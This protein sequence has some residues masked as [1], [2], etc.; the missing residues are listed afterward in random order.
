M[1]I[2]KGSVLIIHF[3]YR[4]DTVRPLTSFDVKL[5]LYVIN[6]I[7]NSRTKQNKFLARRLPSLCH[8]LRLNSLKQNEG[9]GE[10][11]GEVVPLLN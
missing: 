10:G 11:E 4:I 8:C 6:V 7:S 5:L 9:E 1:L 2:L 3:V